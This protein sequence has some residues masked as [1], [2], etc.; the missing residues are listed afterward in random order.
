MPSTNKGIAKAKKE[1][2]REEAEI[3]NAAWSAMTPEHQIADLD[4][5]GMDAKKQRARIEARM[6]NK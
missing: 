2:R 1:Q 3:R 6:K 5:R 4:A